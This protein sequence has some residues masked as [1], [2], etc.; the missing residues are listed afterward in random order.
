MCRKEKK[1]GVC[2]KVLRTGSECDRPDECSS[3][4][5]CIGDKK[6]CYNDC[7]GKSCL[8]GTIFKTRVLVRSFGL[9]AV[10]LRTGQFLG[11]FRDQQLG[12]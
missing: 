10:H 12:R 5:D 1:D 3:D 7:G 2:P 8:P 6:C 11:S 4:S 9:G